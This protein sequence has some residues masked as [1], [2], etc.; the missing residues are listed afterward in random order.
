LRERRTRIVEHEKPEEGREEMRQNLAKQTQ[1]KC[2]TFGEFK[3][4]GRNRNLMV[5]Y[6]WIF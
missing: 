2:C 4:R 6:L 5:S 3:V 1:T